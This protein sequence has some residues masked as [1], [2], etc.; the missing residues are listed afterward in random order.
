[1]MGA[2]MLQDSEACRQWLRVALV[3]VHTRTDTR[4]FGFDASAN[5]TR[6]YLARRALERRRIALSL[7]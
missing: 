1:M 2:R 6:T 4:V 7:T 5:N 3:C